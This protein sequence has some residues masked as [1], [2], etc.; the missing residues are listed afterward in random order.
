MA[1]FDQTPSGQANVDLVL[2]SL[3]FVATSGTGTWNQPNYD[4]GGG[5]TVALTLG[6]A[7]SITMPAGLL[8]SV[9]TVSSSTA[10]GIF[11]LN[12][13]SAAKRLGAWPAPP[14]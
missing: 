11:T 5:N 7:P 8:G 14:A 6:G 1:N 4:W 10:P 9:A 13:Q 12:E 2:P 3:A